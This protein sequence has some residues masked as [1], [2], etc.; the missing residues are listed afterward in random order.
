M[1]SSRRHGTATRAAILKTRGLGTPVAG[2]PVTV[3]MRQS[4]L[5]IKVLCHDASEAAGEWLGAW[6]RF[7]VKPTLGEVERQ[8]EGVRGVVRELEALKRDLGGD[9]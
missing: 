2:D 4:C 3:R 7:R 6:S 8:L 5:Q 1:K 9:S